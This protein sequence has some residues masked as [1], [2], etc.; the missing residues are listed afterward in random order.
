MLASRLTVAARRIPVA[1]LVRS[2]FPLLAVSAVLSFAS[3]SHVASLSASGAQ[4]IIPVVPEEDCG[5]SPESR[6]ALVESAAAAQ[7]ASGKPSLAQFRGEIV[8]DMRTGE[9]VELGKL[10]SEKPAVLAFLRR[11]G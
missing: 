1:R 6:T 2:A 11:L 5:C 3:S 8:T 7:M 9:T 10:Y 4:N